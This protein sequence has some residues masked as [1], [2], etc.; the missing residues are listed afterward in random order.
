MLV[1]LTTTATGSIGFGQHCP[2][3]LAAL[4]DV[5]TGSDE[6]IDHRFR[7]FGGN[8]K[9]MTI[10]DHVQGCSFG[11]DELSDAWKVWVGTDRVALIEKDSQ[12]FEIIVNHGEVDE[13]MTFDSPL[14][15]VWIGTIFEEFFNL[16]KCICAFL[17][18]ASR[19]AAL[20]GQDKGVRGHCVE[21]RGAA[22]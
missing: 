14:Q 10:P 2:A 3:S 5:C 19:L 11:V 4:V 1:H 17:L 15:C 21:F 22:W 18:A 9:L 8:T 20:E 12:E 6:K 7:G 16:R 13:R